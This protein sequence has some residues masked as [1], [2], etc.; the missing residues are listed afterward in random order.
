MDVSALTVLWLSEEYHHSRNCRKK[1]PR[2]REVERDTATP[3]AACDISCQALC[4]KL[5]K[6]QKVKSPQICSITRYVYHFFGGI[7]NCPSK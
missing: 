6:P 5:Q 2:E 3:L 7:V 4:P 1:T